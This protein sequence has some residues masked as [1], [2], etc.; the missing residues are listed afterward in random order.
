[1]K[2]FLLRCHRS[3]RDLRANDRLSSA[4]YGGPATA[5]SPRRLST[6][7]VLGAVEL[8]LKFQ[9]DTGGKVIGF[10]FYNCPQ[11]TS[12]HFGNLCSAAGALLAIVTFSGETAGSW[13]Q[14][15]FSSPITLRTETSPLYN[16]LTDSNRRTGTV[17]P[18]PR[19]NGPLTAPSNAGSGG[20]EV[21]A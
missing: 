7:M 18:A 20:N 13:Q 16:T 11:N 5:Y 19:S 21:Y 4:E 14:S 3:D 2:K 1:V 10:R 9:A 15:Y 17:R 8:A 6:E 12:F